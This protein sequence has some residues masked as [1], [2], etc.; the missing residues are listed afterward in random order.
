ML[1]EYNRWSQGACNQLDY[2]Q[3]A[4][5][6]LS[7]VCGKSFRKECNKPCHKCI[8]ERHLPVQDQT[9]AIQCS[10]CQQWFRS[11]GGLAVHKCVAEHDKEPA[12][13]Q[14]VTCMVCQ[15]DLRDISV[16]AYVE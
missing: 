6:V 14:A 15:R 4:R 3:T 13:P 12:I 5:Q 2:Q 8:P 11:K 10:F 7:S 1:K 16:T 9:G